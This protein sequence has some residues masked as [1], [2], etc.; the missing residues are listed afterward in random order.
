MVSPAAM[1]TDMIVFPSPAIDQDLGLTMRLEDFRIEQ[2]PLPFNQVTQ[3][4][5]YRSAKPVEIP[6]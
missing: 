3:I 6:V 4:D 1:K 2:F 5:A